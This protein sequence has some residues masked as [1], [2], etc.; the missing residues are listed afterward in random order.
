MPYYEYFLCY[1][2]TAPNGHF[3]AK[4]QGHF[5]VT[6]TKTL[7]YLW[8]SFLFVLEKTCTTFQAFLSCSNMKTNMHKRHFQKQ[9]ILGEMSFLTIFSKELMYKVSWTL[10]EV[11]WMMTFPFFLFKKSYPTFQVFFSCSNMKTNMHKRHFQKQE[12]LGEMSFL[13]IF[14]KE[15][16]QTTRC[17]GRLERCTG[18]WFF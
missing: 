16:K 1:Y 5:R 10:R 4:L 9:E 6:Q 17:P 12:I 8:H 18:I 15:L 2:T 13:T 3:S 7:A 11:Y 14:S